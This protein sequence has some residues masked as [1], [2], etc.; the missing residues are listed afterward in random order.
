MRRYWDGGPQAHF[1]SQAI[2]LGIPLFSIFKLV[3]SF[4][5]KDSE[6]SFL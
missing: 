2:F 3:I 1:L 6:T 4:V 5:Y